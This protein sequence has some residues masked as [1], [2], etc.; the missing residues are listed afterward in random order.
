M[1]PFLLLLR[2]L[3]IKFGTSVIFESRNLS[4]K[5]DPICFIFYFFLDVKQRSLEKDQRCFFAAKVSGSK[6]SANPFSVLKFEISGA[7]R[8]LTNGPALHA[9]TNG[10]Q[11]PL[12]RLSG[13]GR[14][15]HRGPTACGCNSWV[16]GAESLHRAIPEYRSRY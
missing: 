16:L 7:M 5:F 1:S 13:V 4:C 15:H 6:T 2:A 9:F 14:S 12:Q 3:S 10:V 8:Q 11:V